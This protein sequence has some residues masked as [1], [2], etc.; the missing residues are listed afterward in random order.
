LFLSWIA[1]IQKQ[2]LWNWVPLTAGVAVC[3]AIRGAFPEIEIQ[4]KWPNDLWIHGSKVGG[5]LCEGAKN[6]F[7]PYIVIG[8]GINCV[9]SPKGLD[10]E[11]TDLTAARKGLLTL[12]DLIRSSVIVALMDELNVLEQFGSERIKSAYQKWAVFSEGT[13]VEWGN[14]VRKGIVK[15]LGLQGEL[16]VLS[17]DGQF[18]SIFAD[19][20]KVLKSTPKASGGFPV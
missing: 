8:I 9:D 16:Q 2:N 3:K 15:D 10:Q 20:V 4:Q 6:Q 17:N 14:P 7:G 19:D 11:A 13:S 5:I 1:R 18:V 12:A